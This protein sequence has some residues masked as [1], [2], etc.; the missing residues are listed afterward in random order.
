MTAHPRPTGVLTL[1]GGQ[2][3]RVGRTWPADGNPVFLMH[4]SPSCRVMWSGLANAATATG[5]R[6]IVPDRPG[7][8]RSTHQPGRRLADWPQDVAALARH[9][10][11]ERY[12]VVGLSG[13]GPY[14]L[15][16][17]A[18]DARL[19][20][21]AVVN[22]IGPL[23]TPESIAGLY[24][25]NRFVFEAAAKGPEALAPVVSQLIGVAGGGA[26][27]G[28]GAGGGEAGGGGA[29]GGGNRS[30]AAMLA[31]MSPEDR[32]NAAAHPELLADTLDMSETAAAWDRGRYA[33]PLAQRPAL[34]VRPGR[35]RRPG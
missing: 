34:G 1:A 5:T 35:H 17:A 19:A 13:G 20:G 28:G 26:A 30:L 33:R 23:D 25:T 18:A 11:L 16:C 12:Q 21:T 22:G 3:A 2:P 10:G 4:G 24:D 31:G 9:L 8:G 27:G 7:C 32:A 29:G 15:A 6:L 14:A